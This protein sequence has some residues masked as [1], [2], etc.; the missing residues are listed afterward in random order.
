MK[1]TLKTI[2]MWAALLVAVLSLAACSVDS[3]YPQPQTFTMT[4]S[5]QKGD[6]ATR[7]VL[8][9]G[10]G[11]SIA[12]EWSV[13]D[14]VTAMFNISKSAPLS[15]TL[16]AQTAGISTT[17]SGSLTGDVDDGDQIVLFYGST[18]VN[19]SS[20]SSQLGTLEDIAENFDNAVAIVTVSVS[21]DR[22]SSS[23]DVVFNSRQ[24]IVK[25]T[26]KNSTG[27]SELSASQVKVATKNEYN[28]PISITVTPAS[29]TSTLYVALPVLAP[30]ENKPVTIIATVGGNKYEC[31]K[32]SATFIGG[33]YYRVS[34][35]LSE[36]KALSAVTDED[37]GKVIGSDGVIYS[38]VSSAEASGAD[39]SGIIAYVGSVGSVDASSDSYK[40]LAISVTDAPN[41]DQNHWFTSDSGTCSDQNNTPATAITYMNGIQRTA[42]L[43]NGHSS[44]THAAAAAAKNFSTARP[45]GVSAWF[46][47]SVGQWNLI[48]QGL[49][50]KKAGI[51]V[52]TDMSSSE[53]NSYKRT[54]LNSVLTDAGGSGFSK[55]TTTD[56]YYWSCNEFDT[57]NAWIINFDKGRPGNRLK[58]KFAYVR[59]VFAF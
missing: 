39:A 41:K 7:G 50:T 13:G 57:Q 8:T 43:T 19:N 21:G 9:D 26:L 1:K 28:D 56:P 31:V 33:D 15:G 36:L 59:P 58:S 22:I 51:P 54:N 34:A 4:V 11:S 14:V 44:H 20:Y 17:L 40:G 53:N 12:A 35:K 24:A 55:E 42:E 38:S 52:S 37:L 6:K 47:P 25:F 46:L 16:T 27:T 3:E 23:S 18:A 45:D 48:V 2:R 32:S 5:A 29:A 10:G 49:A 30:V